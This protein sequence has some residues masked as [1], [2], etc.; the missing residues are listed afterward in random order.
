MRHASRHHFSFLVRSCSVAL[1]LAGG[2]VLS[3]CD[4]KPKSAGMVGSGETT[5]TAADGQTTALL[6]LA[7]P[8]NLRTAQVSATEILLEWDVPADS[9]DGYSIQRKNVKTGEVVVLGDML[10]GDDRQFPDFVEPDTEY[11]Y[12]IR[13]MKDEAVSSQGSNTVTVKSEPPPATAPGEVTAKATADNRVSLMWGESPGV[14]KYTILR[15]EKEDSG[16]VPIETVEGKRAFVDRDLDPDTTYWYKVQ[17]IGAKGE[18]ADSTPVKTTTQKPERIAQ[19]TPNP[20]P[21]PQATP[22]P[23]PPPPPPPDAW[24]PPP[25]LTFGQAV[26]RSVQVLGLSHDAV[27][28]QWSGTG[29]AFV[30]LRSDTPAGPYFPLFQPGAVVRY[31]DYDLWPAT[32]YF[33]KVRVY[34]MDGR[35]AETE[36]LRVVTLP[37]PPS[38][39]GGWPPIV[40]GPVLPP[41][42]RPEPPSR[43]VADE[44]SYNQIRLAWD[45]VPYADRYMVLRSDRGSER[46]FEPID[47]V[48]RASYNDLD[49]RADKTYWY[50]VR[51]LVGG[52]DVSESRTFRFRTP[53]APEA[54]P[55]P[56]P[57][58][59]APR[60]VK[61]KA[62]SPTQVNIN[63]TESSNANIFTVMRAERRNGE[64]FPL[65]RLDNKWNYVDRDVEPDTEYWYK[66]RARNSSSSESTDSSAESVRTPKV[67]ATP[68]PAP[69]A[70]PTPAPTATPTPVPTATPT[71][72]PTATPTP[73]P[74]AT[75]TPA[76]TATPT[77]EPTATPTPVPTATPTPEPTATP[78]PAVTRTPRPTRTPRETPDATVT[79]SP[80]P[81]A[82]PTPDAE[83]TPRP[84]RVP[85]ETPEVQPVTPGPTTSGVKPAT[86]DVVKKP[87]KVG[88]IESRGGDRQVQ[89]R[90]QNVNG[91]DAYQVM[92]SDARDGKYEQ[93]GAM[94][95][96]TQFVDTKVQ[97]GTEYWYKVRTVDGEAT[98]DSDPVSVRTGGAATREAVKIEEKKPAVITPAP[99][100]PKPEV[101]KPKPE[102]TAAPKNT[103]EVKSETSPQKPEAAREN[104]RE[105]APVSQDRVT[106]EAVYSRLSRENR[107]RLDR[108]PAV[109]QEK[110]LEGL[111]QQA[112]RALRRN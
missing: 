82:A 44:I 103:P 33:Y 105:A 99:E 41:G 9:V 96:R 112:E 24:Q 65:E 97:P 77:P 92:R 48:R 63:W 104:V 14:S 107:A 108:L 22:A 25:P 5:G 66:I 31:E 70:T 51:P 87:G 88:R 28:M 91:V 18:L 75:P 86:S 20:T 62:V 58:P 15:S 1:L 13:S 102:V 89:M 12:Q 67:E 55:T 54:T 32:P 2:L 78:T 17:S 37:P 83:R 93:V 38:W 73:A 94:R 30:L 34:A 68:T 59:T 72:V 60:T 50:R 61:V 69:T 35:F 6:T 21:R 90:W 52:V 80:D 64:Y 49:V 74:T 100:T 39:G 53:A 16:F 110:R 10:W 98:T 109:E 40:P 4:P 29:S 43:I 95:G 85:R 57:A 23:Q 76:P 84:T 42:F 106:T 7:P 36:A 11:T 111:R 45:R 19:S 47:T 8:T 46:G 81:T 56:A 101:V 79:P 3:G 27:L 71:P 26:V